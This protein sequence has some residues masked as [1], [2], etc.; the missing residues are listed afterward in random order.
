MRS[1]D[2]SARSRPAT[3]SA[4]ILGAAAISARFGGFPSRL[5]S[6]DRSPNTIFDR[7]KFDSPSIQQRDARS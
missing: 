3:S 6:Q 1:W 5:E 7:F 2:S 4:E